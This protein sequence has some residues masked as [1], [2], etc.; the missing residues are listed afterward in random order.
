MSHEKFNWHGKLLP[1]EQHS[2][3]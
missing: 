2:Q 3:R 1:L